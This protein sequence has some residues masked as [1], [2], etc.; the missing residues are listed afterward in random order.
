MDVIGDQLPL[1]VARFEQM[2]KR[3]VLSLQPLL[4]AFAFVRIHPAVDFADGESPFLKVMPE[5]V[6][7]VAVLGKDEQ[8]AARVL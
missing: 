2:A 3:G 4:G 8:P 6:Q 7:R 5:L 1:V